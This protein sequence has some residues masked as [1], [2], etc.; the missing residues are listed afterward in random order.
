MNAVLVDNSD[1]CGS[2]L[3][4]DEAGTFNLDIA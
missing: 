2:G 1:H 3:A 4:R